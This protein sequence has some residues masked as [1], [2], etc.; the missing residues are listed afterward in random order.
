MSGISNA[1]RQ[2]LIETWL[3]S[4]PKLAREFNLKAPRKV[5]VTIDPDVD[6]VAYAYDNEIFISGKYMREHPKD[7]D[8]VRLSA[9]RR[10]KILK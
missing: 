4:Y 6:G 7:V 1:T 8:V 9:A 2:K 3:N 10:L 5:R